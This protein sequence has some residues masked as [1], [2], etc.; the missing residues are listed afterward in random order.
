V[1][2]VHVDTPYVQVIN[3]EGAIVPSQIDAFWGS[4]NSMSSEIYMVRV[5]D[6]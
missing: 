5:Y 1:V 4:K 2:T 3:P 6:G